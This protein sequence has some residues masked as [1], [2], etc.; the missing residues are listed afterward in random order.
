M[1]V[2]SIVEKMQNSGKF[3]NNNLSDKDEREKKEANE[4]NELWKMRLCQVIILLNFCFLY[5]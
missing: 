3:Q 4:A 5:L 1:Y 2:I